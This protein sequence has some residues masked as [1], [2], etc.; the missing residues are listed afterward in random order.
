MFR[1]ISSP[2]IGVDG[3]VTL[4]KEN[5]GG[6]D[7]ARCSDPMIMAHART[8]AK[9]SSGLFARWGGKRV[10]AAEGVGVERSRDKPK[11]RDAI[12]PIPRTSASVVSSN[13][14]KKRVSSMKFIEDSPM[15]SKFLRPITY[16]TV[17]DTL[18][19]RWS[20]SRSSFSRMALALHRQCS[21]SIARRDSKEDSSV[22]RNRKQN[23]K[24]KRWISEKISHSITRVFRLRHFQSIGR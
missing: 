14:G 8:A 7:W 20:F 10:G 5:T 21:T 17:T 12:S 23:V 3:K 6:A 13:G 16:L 15:A 1:T 11:P 18:Q 22:L 2:K 19:G 4:F 9:E 24:L